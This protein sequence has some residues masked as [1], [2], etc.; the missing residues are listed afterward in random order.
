M[1]RTEADPS[2]QDQPGSLM[3]I[4]SV[5]ISS[6][7]ESSFINPV[8]QMAT[9]ETR[10]LPS[11]PKLSRGWRWQLRTK[12]RVPKKP[13]CHRPSKQYPSPTASNSTTKTIPLPRK[14]PPERK[15]LVDN[16]TSTS[17]SLSLPVEA[18]HHDSWNLLNS[19]DVTSNSTDSEWV[20]FPGAA[21]LQLV[22]Q[23]L[24]STKFRYRRNSTST[25]IQSQARD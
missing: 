22:S 5:N 25:C 20:S 10:T 18:P 7:R 23:R 1:A 13:D 17:L 24:R 16:G 4:T 8:P 19:G 12:R 6:S 21:E 14:L 3:D 9:Q 2:L 11:R 15:F